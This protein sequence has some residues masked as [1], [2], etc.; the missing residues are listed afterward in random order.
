MYYEEKVIDGILCWRGTPT[1]GWLPKTRRELTAALVELREFLED[2]N[3]R[4]RE[5]DMCE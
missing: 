2:L 3:D 5:R 1:G 4:A